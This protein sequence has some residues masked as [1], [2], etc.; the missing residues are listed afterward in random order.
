ML[1][2]IARCN[3]AL[4]VAEDYKI[5]SLSF[6][7]GC[8]AVVALLVQLGFPDAPKTLVPIVLIGFIIGMM[9]IR[10]GLSD[11]L[12]VVAISLAIYAGLPLFTMPESGTLNFGLSYY[13]A[14]LILATASVA[15]IFS[16][17][18]SVFII[19]APKDEPSEVSQRQDLWVRASLIASSI[20]VVLTA[21]YVL[22]N[23]TVFTGNKQYG[24]MFLARRAAGSGILL[25]GVPLAVAGLCLYLSSGAKRQ[26]NILCLN[27]APFVFLY[28]THMQR[29]YL[30]IPAIIYA[31]RVVRVRSAARVAVILASILVGLVVFSYAGYLR[32]NNIPF[33]EALSEKSLSSFSNQSSDRT[34]GGE[35]LMLYATASSAYGGQVTALPWAGDYFLAPMMSLPQFVFGRASFTS[36][37][38]RFAETVTRAAYLRGGG[39]GFSFFGEAFAVGGFAAVVLVTFIMVLGFRWLYVRARGSGWQGVA[40]AV[41]LASLPNALWF[42]RN[43]FA[44]FFREFLVIQV[45]TILLVVALA[46]LLAHWS[47]Q[48]SLRVRSS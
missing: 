23:G 3:G 4:L 7:F 34:I 26:F 46:F 10:Q 39:W 15:V 20:S 35:T 40:S 29:K 37:N 1:F 5:A 13:G 45:F 27:F 48:K 9:M 41:C 25:L 47:G 24:E 36:L 38:D 21:V 32:I 2:V 28:V 6:G 19:R 18:L 16:I 42:Q 44:Y 22:Q 30:I 31:A 43:A 14:Y 11:P 8:L 12:V 17:G 33:S